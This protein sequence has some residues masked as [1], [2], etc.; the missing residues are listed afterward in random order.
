MNVK[1]IGISILLFFITSYVI[2][3][4]EVEGF[5]RE[6][7]AHHDA[8]DYTKALESYKKALDLEPNSAMV[9]YEMALSY[10]SKGDYENAIKHSDI[11]LDQKGEFMLQAYMT[12]GSALDMQGKTKESIK[13]FEK[14][15]KKTEEHYLLYFNLSI[16]YVKIGDLKKAEKNIKRAIELNSNHTS[17]HFLLASIEDQLSNTIQSI[18]ALNYFL[19][20]EPNSERSIKAHELLMKQFGGN[21]SVDKDKPNTINI[22]L[23]PSKDSEFADTE[24]MLSILIASKLMDEK[25]DKTEDEK[26]I[27]NLKSLFLLLAEKEEKKKKEI[28]W[29]LYIPFFAE[30]AE[31]DHFE[32]YCKYIT[33]SGNENSKKWL[34]ENEAYLTDFINWL[35][36]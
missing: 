21:V 8:G 17:S 29:T 10:F 9:N 25:E 12:K 33:Q 30:L 28:W 11:V 20:L 1:Q 3:Q 27:E 15:I 22:S 36:K 16:N 18:L 6:G 5:I 31:S 23:S 32:L 13:L 34:K 24:L 26:F 2:A 35:K 14:A 19:L 4:S 7:I